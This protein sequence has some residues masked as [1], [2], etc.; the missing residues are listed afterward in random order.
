M[1]THITDAYTPLGLDP[2]DQDHAEFL[3]LLRRLKT[4]QDKEFPVLFQHMMEHCEQHFERENQ[5]MHEY[6]FP[7]E[8]E[9]RKEHRQVLNELRQLK[10]QVDQD[11]LEHCH[12]FLENQFPQWFQLHASTMDCAL[13]FHINIML[14]NHE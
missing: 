8:S 7:A 11:R 1:T 6:S 2:I 13:V 9:H 14:S 3:Q 10:Q 5:L 4:C 12:A